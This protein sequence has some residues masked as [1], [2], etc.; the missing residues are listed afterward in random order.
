VLVMHATYNATT[1]HQS[2]GGTCALAADL[3]P[4]KAIAISE[5]SWQRKKD[6]LL[7]YNEGCP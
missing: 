4:D 5:T 2:M 7:H 3:S 1:T 6:K